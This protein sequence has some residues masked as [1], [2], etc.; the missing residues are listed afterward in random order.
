MWWRQNLDVPQRDSSGRTWHFRVWHD[1][2]EGVYQQRIFFWS[3]DQQ[4]T[5]VVEF[6]ES[7]TL[8][9][10]RLRQR[11]RKLTH[12]PEYRRRFLRPL[13]FPVERYYSDD[14]SLQE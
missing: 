14:G 6:R 5:G 4:E 1:F 10:N 8:H 12:D 9:A 7:E 3:A 11:I 2:T 13:Q